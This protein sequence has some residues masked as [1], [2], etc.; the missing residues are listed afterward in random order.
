MLLRSLLPTDSDVEQ[1]VL[2]IGAVVQQG[3]VV[4]FSQKICF[5]PYG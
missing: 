1:D 4:P 5:I 2:F 3:S